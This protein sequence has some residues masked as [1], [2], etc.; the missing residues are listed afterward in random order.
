M[1]PLSRRYAAPPCLFFCCRVSLCITPRNY[2]L[3]YLALYGLNITF[4]E[5]LMN[6]RARELDAQGARKPERTPHACRGA[7][8]DERRTRATTRPTGLPPRTGHRASGARWPM[9]SDEI[10]N[11][12]SQSHPQPHTHKFY[13]TPSPNRPSAV[14]SHRYRVL[15]HSSITHVVFAVPAAGPRRRS[16]RQQMTALERC[17]LISNEAR[18]APPSRR[19]RC[20]SACVSEPQLHRADTEARS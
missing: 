20:L 10:E 2:L 9:R 17:K 19:C 11:P 8:I 5:C 13:L 3:L 7:R 4:Y 12:L 16:P 15:T 1:F 14:Y 6:A 18:L